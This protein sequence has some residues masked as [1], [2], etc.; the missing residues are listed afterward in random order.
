MICN[1]IIFQ[2]LHIMMFIP[3]EG[4]PF[5]FSS[6]LPLR[7]A[8]HD[9]DIHVVQFC[10]IYGKHTSQVQHSYITYDTIKKKS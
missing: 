7:L 9:H 3:N 6:A 8:Q 1:T 5:T 2:T 4:S 10:L